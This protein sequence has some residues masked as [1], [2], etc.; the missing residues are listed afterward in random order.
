[1]SPQEYRQAAELELQASYE[2]GYELSARHIARAQVY[3]L[4][5][6]SAVNVQ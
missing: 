1:M 2:V 4:L 6:L 5:A 3:A